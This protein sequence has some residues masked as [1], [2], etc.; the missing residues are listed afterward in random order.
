MNKIFSLFLSFVMILSVFSGM[1]ITAQAASYADNY[2]QWSQNKSSIQWMK[3]YGCRY[4]ADAKLIYEAGI[5]RAKSFNPDVYYNKEK[6]DKS[7]YYNVVDYAKSKDNKLSFVGRTTSNNDAK[8]LSNA[9]NGLYSIIEFSGHFVLADNATTKAK[10][11]VYYYDS[12]GYYY[13]SQGNYVLAN[14]TPP[15]TTENKKT[16]KA[17]LTYKYT[18]TV[19]T[20]TTPTTKVTVKFN[21]NGGTVKGSSSLSINK[22]ASIGTSIPSAIRKGYVFNG[23]Y[24]ASSGG[25]KIETSTTISSNITAY[26]HWYESPYIPAFYPSNRQSGIFRIKNVKSG[27]YLTAVKNENGSQIVQSS[28][29]S[30]SSQLWRISSDIDEG[31]KY[32]YI[33]NCNGG[34]CLDMRNGSIE[35]STAL[36]LFTYGGGVNKRWSILGRGNGNY[37]IHSLATGRAVDIRGGSTDN[38]AVV[39][40][41]YY[42][43]SEAQLFKFEEM[44]TRTIMFYDNISNNYLTSLKSNEAINSYTTRDSSAV[45]VSP[46]KISGILTINSYKAGK[47]GEDMQFKTTV[48]GSRN[49][50]LYCGDTS[51]K[52]L[53]FRAKSSVSGTKINF[54]WGYDSSTQPCAVATLSTSWQTYVLTLPR[55]SDS[56]S[57]LHPWIDRACTIQMDNIALVDDTVD[58]NIGID[59]STQA[60]TYDITN[61]EYINSMNLPSPKENKYDCHFVGWFTKRY[62][63]MSLKG[64]DM[65]SIGQGSIK[66]YAHWKEHSWTNVSDVPATCT[67]KGYTLQ[68]CSCGEERKVNYYSINHDFSDNSPTCKLCGTKNPNYVDTTPSSNSPSVN[69]SGANNNS[70]A[71]S[72][73]NPSEANNNSNASSS[74]AGNSSNGYISSDTFSSNEPKSTNIKKNKSAKKAVSVEW[75]KVSGVSGYEIQIATDKKF[76]KNKKTVTVKKQKTTKTTVKK[77]KAKKKYYVRIRTYKIV[78]GKKIY[79]SW[80]KVKSVKTK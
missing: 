8:V 26:A 20:P 27:K 21:S 71:S 38:G 5:D 79:S 4:V 54:R 22:G 62:G 9:K 17:V 39:Q 18:G 63:G 42:N 66:A 48:Q 40:S 46:N 77:L 78:N 45:T 32:Q 23:W 55:T 68:R 15:V 28:Y 58:Y 2:K 52:K 13:N 72:S 50:D 57:N 49:F 30:S 73:T 1:T 70:T 59:D 10:N 43:A 12:Y 53:V 47:C 35:L 64:W 29:S 36:Q 44:P 61:Q 76:K 80:S 56:G 51:S 19:N 7:S 60:V 69:P 14:G 6:G 67:Q 3:Q 31:E 74:V 37:S 33:V 25:S 24:T 34:K 16:I 11:K 65:I 41:Y 75:K